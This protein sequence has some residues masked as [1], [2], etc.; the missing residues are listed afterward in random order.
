MF[1][2]NDKSIETQRLLLRLF[3]KTDAEKVTKMC[4][5]YNV[6]KSTLSLPHPYPIEC[7]ISWIDSHEEN[8]DTD[9]SFAFAITDKVSGELYGCISISNNQTSK[10]GEIGYWIGEEYW[11]RGIATEAVQSIIKFA[12]DIKGYHRVYARHYASNPASGKVMIK[13]GMEYEGTQKEHIY[14][15]D[16]YEDVV[17]YGVVKSAI[18][19]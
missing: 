14:K 16:V 2:Y 6:Y 12:F 15:L 4:N 9:K 5:N 8:F 17:L 19:V 11:G 3:N 7:A 10:N 1:K 18:R 13:A